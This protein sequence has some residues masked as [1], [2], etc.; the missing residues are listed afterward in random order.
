MAC[1]Y[2]GSE[3]GTSEQGGGIALAVIEASSRPPFS[4]TLPLGSFGTLRGQRW[5]VRLLRA[6]REAG[7]STEQPFEDVISDG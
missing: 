6:C 4:P 7:I 1:S 2:C 5:Q 3:L